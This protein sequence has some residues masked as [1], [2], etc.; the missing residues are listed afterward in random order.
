M[1][2]KDGNKAPVLE[3][4]IESLERIAKTIGEMDSTIQSAGG[5][6]SVAR[7]AVAE[8]ITEETRDV[9][10]PT[11]NDFER[12]LKELDEPKV[13]VGL[14]EHMVATLESF[15]PVADE[16]VAQVVKEKHQ[17]SATDIA[18]IKEKRA[19]QVKTFQALRLILE[20]AGM[21]VSSVEE[22]KALRGGGRPAGGGGGTVKVKGKYIF[23]KDGKPLA[24]SQQ[25]SFSSLS[26]YGTTG[27]QIVDG[28]I[29][30][31]DDKKKHLGAKELAAY[32]AKN[33]INY[34][35][36]DEWEIALPNGRTIGARRN[37]DADEKS[38]STEATSGEA[39]A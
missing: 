12:Y 11:V 27:L 33:G 10:E 26:W 29:V 8:A 16:V 30:A 2:Q 15:K 38:E 28:E 19:V 9:W 31:V 25:G 6:E 13:L 18:A 34:G 14:I 7:K 3:I 23:L 1:A 21:D 24:D 22:P 35:Q 17:G 39:A 36:D 4:S 37:P 32:L 20:G 5:K